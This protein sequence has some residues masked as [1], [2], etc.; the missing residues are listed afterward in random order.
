MVVSKSDYKTLVFQVEQWVKLV[1]YLLG[2]ESDPKITPFEN[3]QSVIAGL[4]S[5]QT[6]LGNQLKIAN[7]NL[8]LANTEVDNQK[9]KLANREAEWQRSL[10]TQKAE[11]E[12]KISAMPNVSKLEG[13]Y[14]GV[15]EDL[16]GKLR[17]YQKAVGQKDLE[18][19]EMKGQVEKAKLV[20]LIINFIKKL[21]GR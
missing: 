5:T 9:D 4:K 7:T 20:D 13:Q 19:A 8:T 10:K 3:C 21:L 11:Y 16:E 2:A 1:G 18:I 15:I 14:K 6:D 12:A 17:V